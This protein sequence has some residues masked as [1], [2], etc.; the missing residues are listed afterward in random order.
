MICSCEVGAL[1]VLASALTEIEL[2]FS[3]RAS[4]PTAAGLAL[5]AAERSPESPDPQLPPTVHVARALNWHEQGGDF[6]VPALI[7]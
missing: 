1:D 2:G 3:P 7:S 6:P 4:F 5:F